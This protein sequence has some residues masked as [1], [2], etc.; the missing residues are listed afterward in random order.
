MDDGFTGVSCYRRPIFKVWY[1]RIEEFVPMIQVLLEVLVGL[2]SLTYILDWYI[3][4]IYVVAES[5]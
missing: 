1:A 2:H 3:V 5:F 4:W